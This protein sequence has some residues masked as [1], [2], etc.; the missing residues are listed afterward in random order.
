[1]HILIE[2][3][4]VT[5]PVAV[6]A[7][8]RISS[9]ALVAFSW[10]GSDIEAP[11]GLEDPERRGR[12]AVVGDDSGARGM[13]KTATGHFR[14][15]DRFPWGRRAGGQPVGEDTVWLSVSAC[16][17][18]GQ[19]LRHRVL[20]F[21]LGVSGTFHAAGPRRGTGS[22]VSQRGPRETSRFPESARDQNQIGPVAGTSGGLSRSLPSQGR[23]DDLL[24]YLRHFC[25][26]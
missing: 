11:G 23:R 25:N 15:A 1:M 12:I 4:T 22:G 18:R 7:N 26:K 8:R 16:L 6:S 19:E 14:R 5:L 20:H 10:H 2:L 24:K 17:R 13:H 21:G 3:K 9:A